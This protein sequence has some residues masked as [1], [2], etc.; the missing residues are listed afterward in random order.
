M[1]ELEATFGPPEASGLLVG[2]DAAER[3]LL[4]AYRSERIHHAWLIEGPEGIGK[5]TLAY[6]FARFVIRHPEP[7]APAVREAKDLSV[8]ATDPTA[9]QI[10]MRAHPNLTVLEYPRDE[11]GRA[12]KSI[13]PVD[14]VRRVSRFLGTTAAGGNWRIVVV[15]A[16][17]DLNR[18]SANAL[19][20]MLEEPPRRSLF[21]LVSHLP[22]R[23]L[24]T[25]RSRCRRL[26]LKPLAGEV[27]R[28]LMGRAVTDADSEEIDLACSM[29]GG[30]F[31]R[32]LE[33]GSS[34]GTKL[35]REMLALLESLPRAEQLALH[36]LAERL[37]RRGQDEAYALATSLMLDWIAARSRADALSGA[38][39]AQLAPWAQVWEKVSRALAETEI[40]NLDRTQTL[41]TAFRAVSTAAPLES[42]R[43]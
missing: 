30:S 25:I 20:K 8:P 15:D 16:A 4:D 43:G 34:E 22:G 37:G 38:A 19:L 3:A 42:A 35:A 33:I 23:L 7:A 32:A 13:I 2:H 29:A 9:R 31:G 24:P 17:D 26:M 21:L 11:E 41:L 40:Y 5:A 39:P 6:R 36:G 27:V 18:A 1:K 10:A 14:A 28:D 12:T